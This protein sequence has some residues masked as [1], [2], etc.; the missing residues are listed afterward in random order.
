M[1]YAA[2]TVC[3]A[4]IALCSTGMCQTPLTVT[5]WNIEHLGSA[6]RGFG[7]GFGGGSLPPRTDDQL[8]QIAAFVKDELQS[9]VLALQEIGVTRRYRA[10]SQSRPLGVITKQ[11][12]AMGQSWDYYLP[13]VRFTPPQDDIENIHLAF[14]WNTKRVKPHAFFPLGS[15]ESRL[16]WE[17]ALQTPTAG[18]LFLRDQRS[19]SR[20]ERLFARQRP[21][22]FRAG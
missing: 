4:T 3:I 15:S 18:R 6:G 22:W 19:R 9:D 5:T 11:L 12:Q 7:G 13:P 16:G 8:H 21:P 10:A 1:K 20:D 14:M 2:Q 17:G